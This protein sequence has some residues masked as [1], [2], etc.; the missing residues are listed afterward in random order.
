MNVAVRSSSDNISRRPSIWATFQPPMSSPTRTFMILAAGPARTTACASSPSITMP[1][2]ATSGGGGG[3]GGGSGA[4]TTGGGGG[5]GPAVGGDSRPPP[6]A[7]KLHRELLH[8]CAWRPTFE[9]VEE[10]LQGLQTHFQRGLKRDRVRRVV[11]PGWLDAGRDKHRMMD[12]GDLREVSLQLGNGE[13]L[14][15]RV[16]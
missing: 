12:V 15:R 5:G 2:S 16:E 13:T 3:G 8:D 1:N 4:T 6:V 10:C 11:A 14:G 7:G 9:L